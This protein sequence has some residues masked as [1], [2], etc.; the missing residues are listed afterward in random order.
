MSALLVDSVRK[1]YGIKPLLEDVSFSL[2]EGGKMG[3]I[4][5]NGSGKTT[6]LRIIAG[7]EPPDG[8]TVQTPK[9]LAVGYLSQEP[10]F[11]DGQTVLDAVFAGEG[12]AMRLL[13]DY[14]AA[15]RGI[16]RGESNAV[17]RM[18]DLAARLDAVGGWELEA[19]AKAVLGKLGIDDF[20]AEV[21]KLSG[22]QRKRVALA[23][24]LVEQP[25]LLILDE[26]TNHLDAETVSWLEETLRTYPGALLLVTHDRYFLDRVTNSM[27][28]V[29]RG[30]VQRY[31]GNY[32][33]YLEVRAEQ[34]VIREA[35]QAKRD[36]LAKRELAWLR[37]GAKARTT[38]QKAR[39]SRAHALLDAPREEAEK[40][41]EIS[42]VTTRLGKQVVT[43]D[44]VS[45]GFDGQTL[46][47][48]FTYAFTRQDRVGIIGPNGS[49]KTTLLEMIAGRLAPDSGEVTTG[50]TVN[51]G[52]Y[53][54]ESRAL[55]DEMRLID[56]IEEI[57]EN[58]PTSDGGLIT[59]SQ[60]LERFLFPPKQQYTPIG[61]LSGGERRRLYLLR[62]LMGAPNVLLLDEPTNDLDIPTL[63]ALEDYL[64]TFP[65]CL[66]TV[67]HDRY[68]LDRT[69]EHLFRFEGGGAL[70][71]IP[72]NYS[73]WLEIK[74]AE[75]AARAEAAAS[76]PAKRPAAPV[77]AAPK[78]QSEGLSYKEKK[79]LGAVEKRIAEGEARQEAIEAELGA[80]GADLERITE[81]SSELEALL[82]QMEADMERWADLA[83]RA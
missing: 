14:E 45:K 54:Q 51:I 74:A 35:E 37:R 72:G 62:V 21:E 65:G 20:D 17:Q 30:G 19:R 25:G 57:A 24:A 41:A 49:G 22:G 36:N 83:E 50:P 71:G 80:G 58:V 29:D 79:E 82:A 40:T 81:L 28:E 3:V 43:L 39:V 10:H 46:I 1:S 70:R 66:I 11:A 26:P 69:A 63:V 31:E 75:D 7:V 27:L 77:A 44:G 52:Y 76:K 61:L 32:S 9:T 5:A 59:A 78:P 53:D 33:Q 15:L 4:G 55:N 2:E 23:R 47:D 8:G 73:A 48:D 12:P 64:D 16:E 56:Y 13:R 6:L 38:K 60:M 34:A 68:F 18:T 67:S 42:A